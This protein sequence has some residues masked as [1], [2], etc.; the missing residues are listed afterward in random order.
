MPRDRVA[1]VEVI[2][3]KMVEGKPQFLLLKRVPERG[4]F[5]QPVTGGVDEGEDLAEAAKRELLEETQI[6]EIIRL[7]EDVHY[8][9]FESIGFGQLKEY[10]F[11][12]EVAANTEAIISDEHSEMKWCGLE[13]SLETLLHE[14]NKVGFRKLGELAFQ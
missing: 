8:F 4:G 12:V 14:N 2:I 1:Q 6:R 5:W 11:G 9:E 10:V 13:E 7:I 3:F